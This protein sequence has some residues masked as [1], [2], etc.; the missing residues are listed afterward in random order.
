M[1]YSGSRPLTPLRTV[2]KHLVESIVVGS[3]WVRRRIRARWRDIAILSYHNIVP[4]G[5]RPLGDRSLHLPQELFARHLDRLLATHRIVGLDEAFTS[6]R[7]PGDDQTPLAVLTFDDGY[8]GALTAGVEELAQ[9]GL[10]ATVFVNPG[11][12]E[13]EGFWWDRLADP[14]S[15]LLPAGARGQA[16]GPLEGRQDRVLAWAAAAGLPVFE[17]PDYAR[18]AP[19]GILLQAERQ[20]LVRLGSHSWSHPSLSALDGVE[21]RKE[22]GDTLHWLAS[23]CAAPS[24][25]LAWP[26]GHS[27]GDAEVVA[28]ELHPGGLLLSERLTTARHRADRPMGLPR[29]NVPSATSP[30]GLSLRLAECAV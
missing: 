20:G 12:L 13:W 25:W 11:A 23:R 16:L 10:A 2:A 15:G 9:R 3:G 19:E 30:Q 7:D 4:R 17:L 27:S 24:R 21:L 26:Y 8:L 1:V 18:A 14:H 28:A 6:D 29:I 5:E 22:L